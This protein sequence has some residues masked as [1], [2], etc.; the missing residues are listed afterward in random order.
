MDISIGTNVKVIKVFTE[1]KYQRERA[2]C[3]VDK[4]G[5][6]TKKPD[7]SGSQ[8][9]E[10]SKPCEKHGDTGGMFYSDELEVVS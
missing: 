5:K 2:K 8:W 3:F 9:V 6:I 10:F 7:R 4:T 1:G